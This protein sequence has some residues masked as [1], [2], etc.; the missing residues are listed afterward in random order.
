MTTIELK[1]ELI[2]RITEIEDEDFLKAI[3]TILDLKVSSG[4]L[5]LTREQKEEIITSRE[6][7]YKGEV[8]DNE[9]LDKEIKSWLN[10][11]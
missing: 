7:A 3:K 5:N 4:I 8:I 10:E 11:R 1:K 2:H 6:N 9:I